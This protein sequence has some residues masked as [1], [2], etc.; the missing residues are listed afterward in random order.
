MQAYLTYHACTDDAGARWQL[1]LLHEHHSSQRA[2][3]C[4]LSRSDNIGA[5]DRPWANTRCASV[6]VD[7]APAGQAAARPSWLPLDKLASLEL[8]APR[9]AGAMHKLRKGGIRVQM[10]MADCDRIV[11]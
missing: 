10:R 9:A 2:D 3:E 8:P 11:W 5:L 7:S 6:P 4:L 1:D